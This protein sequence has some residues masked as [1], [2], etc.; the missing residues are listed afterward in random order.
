MEIYLV[1][2]KRELPVLFCEDNNIHWVGD[3]EIPGYEQ[4][5]SYYGIVELN[6]S[7][8]PYIALELLKSGRYDYVYYL[9]PDIFVYSLPPEDVLFQNGASIC[10]TPHALSPYPD[11][12]RPNELDLLKFGAFNLGFIG[13]K[14]DERAVNLLLWWWKML[15]DRCFYEPSLGMAVDQKWLDLAPSMFE[16]V[17]I[18]K[19]PG[20]NVAFWNLHERHLSLSEDGI[21]M[22]NDMPLH[23]YHFSSFDKMNLNVVAK[24]QT[25]F[26]ES[27]K[28]ELFQLYKNYSAI[29]AHNESV[30]S[31]YNLAYGVS[32]DSSKQYPDGFRGLT[33]Y[34]LLNP[35]PN[36]TAPQNN[37]CRTL[38]Q[39]NPS[40]D[41]SQD[42]IHNAYMPVS[43]STRKM[44]AR[45]AS[46]LRPLFIFLYYLMGEKRYTMLLRSFHFLS[47]PFVNSAII[48]KKPRTRI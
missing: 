26:L 47:I 28:P 44:L 8:K 19:I 18:C 15:Q 25:R 43:Q 4:L 30:L 21:F 16:G 40:V 36:S 41:Y 11:I 3:L 22:C 9:D 27:S 5:I 45:F 12:L 37:I 13:L 1:D 42:L 38:I 24:K 35:F 33:N 34:H 39:K 31:G 14:A 7:V 10:L 46:I 6:T 23:F 20:C 32:T 2:S 29:I 17:Q 48:A